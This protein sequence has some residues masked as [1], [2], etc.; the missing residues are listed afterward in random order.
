M[1]SYGQCPVKVTT[2]IL[3]VIKSV[4]SRLAL[5]ETSPDIVTLTVERADKRRS[6]TIPR[7]RSENSSTSRLSVVRACL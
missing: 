2:G 6:T 4:T 7:R 1:R 5:T 3:P